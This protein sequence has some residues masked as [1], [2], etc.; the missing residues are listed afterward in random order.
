MS[1][2]KTEESE[3]QVVESSS[4]ESIVEI[5]KEKSTE[6]RFKGESWLTCTCKCGYEIKNEKAIDGELKCPKCKAINK[7]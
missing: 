7:C 4:S 2:L 3:N 5:A 1:K 6:K